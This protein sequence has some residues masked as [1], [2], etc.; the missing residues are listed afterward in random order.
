MKNIWKVLAFVLFIS[1]F[2]IGCSSAASETSKSTD[3]EAEEKVETKDEDTTEE[4][5]NKEEESE[6]EAKASEA[7]KQSLGKAQL[8]AADFII[9][10]Q[11]FHHIAE[12][13]GKGNMDE[14]FL[15][16]V[17]KAKSIVDSIEW[18]KSAEEAVSI[19]AKDLDSMEKALVAGDLEEAKESSE[20]A[21][22]SQH[23]FAH[24]L[25]N[26]VKGMTADDIKAQMM[27]GDYIISSQGFHHM[28]EEV[29]A[30]NLDE[31]F[32]RKVQKA[33]FMLE[34]LKWADETNEAKDAFLAD[35]TE[36]EKALVA[37]DVEA[38][39]GLA[40]AAH[41]TQHDFSHEVGN[42]IKS[43]K[44]KDLK[45]LMMISDYIIAEQGFH[46]MSEEIAAGSMD[47]SFLRNVQ[48]A[49]FMLENVQWPKEIVEVK[50]SFSNDVTEMEKALVSQ[51]SE[52]AKKASYAA[53]ETQHDF[54]H[55]VWKVIPSMESGEVVMTEVSEGH[56]DGT[57]TDGNVVTLTMD[58]W[59]F[60]NDLNLIQ[61][62]NIIKIKNDGNMPHGMM[63]P[64]LGVVSDDVGKGE[65][66]TFEVTVDEKGEYEFFCSVPVCGTP[67]QH[68]GMTGKITVE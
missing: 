11:G 31:G 49:K 29:V 26:I 36:F 2:T 46:H 62:K 51:D 12:E 45:G 67:E 43:L 66:V 42:A 22:E 50:D 3:K 16:N 59:D 56:D 61:G 58:D 64:G 14:G 5:E 7:E 28:A 54:S 37:K 17:K 34:H 10:E 60:K 27:I 48:K 19:F 8:V 9:S 53:H 32:L 25:G 24:E 13:I 44:G 23:D 35:V 15:R 4:P 30:G 38:A 65:T 18:P 63:I 68:G 6:E 33:K 21:H 20:A 55:D 47:E 1:I 39:K 41:E 40:E 57:A 52:A